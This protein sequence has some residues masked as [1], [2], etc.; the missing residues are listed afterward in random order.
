ALLKQRQTNPKDLFARMI[1]Q[2]L[3]VDVHS[4]QVRPLWS[5]PLN[6]LKPLNLLWSKDSGSVLL[7]PTFLPV[8]E[9]PTDMDRTALEGEAIAEVQLSTGVFH[10]VPLAGD[11]EVDPRKTVW[12][13]R[14]H[15]RIQLSGGGLKEFWKEGDEWRERTEPR[16]IANKVASP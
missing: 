6:R 8:S 13:D 9:K 5:A 14:N 10:V 16:A 2:L 12:I 15:L 11:A 4:G 3:V 1:Q 7:W